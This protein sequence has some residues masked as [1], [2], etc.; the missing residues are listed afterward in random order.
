MLTL[1]SSVRI[2]IAAAPVDLRKGFDKLA[3]LARAVIREDPLNGHIFVFLNRQR[4]RVKC[5]WWDRSGWLL[6][7]KKLER[8]T[9]QVPLEPLLGKAH[10]EVDAGEFALMLEGIDLR[11]ATRRRRWRRLPHEL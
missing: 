8:G 5:L 1:P 6:L 9:F 11:G 7:Y 10:V 2:Y 3:Q 4:N